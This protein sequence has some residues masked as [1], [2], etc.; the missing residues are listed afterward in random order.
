ML[1]NTDPIHFAEVSRRCAD[2]LP[3]FSGLF[4][5]YAERLAKP[6]HEFFEGA[7]ARFE[8]DP[9]SCAFFDD[10]EENV[11]AARS[12]G[13]E[14]RRITTDGLDRRNL[15]EWGLLPDPVSCA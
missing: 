11:D 9:A 7:L 8:L 10:R 2:W 5:S 13:I 15:V 6:D 4:L 3:R 14:S 1:S 12:V